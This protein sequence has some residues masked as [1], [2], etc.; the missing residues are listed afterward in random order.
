MHARTAERKGSNREACSG[1]YFG[2]QD[3]GIINGYSG[4][5]RVDW[6]DERLDELTS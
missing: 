6:S 5:M 4:V 1:G 3:V 2:E